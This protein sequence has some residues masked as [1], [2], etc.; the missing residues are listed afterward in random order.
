MLLVSGPLGGATLSSL[1][2]IG[3]ALGGRQIADWLFLPGTPKI[4]SG[5]LMIGI[6]LGLLSLNVLT[7]FAARRPTRGI[8]EIAERR[9]KWK[10]G[11]AHAVEVHSVVAFAVRG[12]AIVARQSHGAEIPLDGIPCSAYA[13]ARLNLLLER[14]PQLGQVM[15]R[16]AA[17]VA[18]LVEE[19][20]EEESG[21]GLGRRKAS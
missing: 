17:N 18:P 7:I 6:S 19:H 15:Y 20:D 4:V 14:P 16:V 13:A 11:L 5:A 21:A 12:G 8:I 3:R 1:V 2:L 10:A 9:V